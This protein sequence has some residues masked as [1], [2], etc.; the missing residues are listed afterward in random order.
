MV[1]LADPPEALRLSGS[2]TIDRGYVALSRWTSVPIE[3]YE[4]FVAR[5]TGFRVYEAGSGWLLA[6][7]EASGAGIE[8]IGRDPAGKLFQVTLPR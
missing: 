5:H 3:P 4:S 8:E 6:K 7:L 2:D 1:Y